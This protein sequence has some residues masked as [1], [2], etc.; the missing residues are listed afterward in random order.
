[1]LWVAQAYAGWLIRNGDLA[2]ASAVAGGVAGWARRDY[3]AALL[4]LQLQHALGTQAPWQAA[5]ERARLLAGERRIP[6]ELE[7]APAPREDDARTRIAVSTGTPP[8]P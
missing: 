1:M 4:Q 5:L 3:D 8:S 2:G 7:R 6:A